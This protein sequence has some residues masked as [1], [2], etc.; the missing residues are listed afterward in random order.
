MDTAAI[1]SHQDHAL[2]GHLLE[3]TEGDCLDYSLGEDMPT[4]AEKYLPLNRIPNLSCSLMG[5]IFN[6][7]DFHFLPINIGSQSWKEGLDIST[8]FITE[9]NYRYFPDITVVSWPIIDVHLFPVRY[10]R[11]FGKQK[12]YDDFKDKAKDVAAK[13]NIEILLKSWSELCPD[14]ENNNQRIVDAIGEAKVI[15]NPTMF[16]YWHFTIDLFPAENSS[17]PINSISSAWKENMAVNLWDVLRHS[18]VVIV[19]N[20]MI[21]PISDKTLWEGTPSVS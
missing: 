21:P 4:I 18:F 1:I 9:D 17:T 13:R 2:L 11:R 19:S 20:E 7:E 10:S 5:S 14:T 15:H 8:D 12:D 6:L 16:N 3:G